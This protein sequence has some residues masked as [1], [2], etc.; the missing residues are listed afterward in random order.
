MNE[1]KA[2]WKAVSSQLEVQITT[3]SYE[4][5]FENL[6]PFTVDN[7]IL[8]L[9]APLKSYK[10][11]IKQFNDAIDSAIKASGT[12]IKGIKIITKDEMDNYLSSLESADDAFFDNEQTQQFNPDYTFDTFVV[13]DSNSIAYAAAKSVAEAPGASHNPLFIYGGVGLGKT[14]IMHAIANY[15]LAHNKNTKIL[16]VTAEQFVNDYI[17]S[18]KNNKDNDLNKQFRQKYRSVDVLMMDDVQFLSGKTS[19]QEALFHTFNDLYQFRK[20]I[21]LTS[22]RHPRE[23]ASLEERLQSRFQSGLT[24]DVT[25]PSIE[26]RIAILQKKAYIK[27]Y[28]I[29]QKAIFFI[30]ENITSNIRELEGA[31]NK[32]VYFCTL[33]SK[34]TEDLDAVKEA[35]KDDIDV[36]THVLSMDSITD[37]VCAYFGVKKAD[38]VGKKKNKLIA[39]ARQIA[40]YLIN[41]ML[42]VPLLAIGKFFGGRDHTTIMYS[43]DKITDAYRN[44]RLIQSQI[45]DIRNML[46]KK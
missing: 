44:D 9:I 21:I 31:L 8:V 32:V 3:V 43:R 33:S 24:V 1:C 25:K 2:I 16:Y 14:H 10:N 41:D 38:I 42:G 22:D 17:D 13:G 20:Q 34:S 23:L 11:T 30:A 40:I 7:D 19:T 5:W 45:N 18:I 36:S 4:I 27:K 35:L 12:G 26:T 39:N 6:E 15:I 28:D 29:S 37:A 46:E